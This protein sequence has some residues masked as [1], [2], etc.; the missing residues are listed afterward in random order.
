MQPF[1]VTVKKVQPNVRNHEIYVFD[2]LA[3]RDCADIRAI[4]H[5]TDGV[6]T[7]YVGDSQ[8]PL[9]VYCDMTTNAVGWTVIFFS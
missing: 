8:R 3:K 7:V 2:L 9:A 4:G 6:Y 1:S 5:T